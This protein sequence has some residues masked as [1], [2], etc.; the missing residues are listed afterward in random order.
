MSSTYDHIALSNRTAQVR[1]EA[2][3]NR[4]DTCWLWTGKKHVR[5]YGRFR[6]ANK[7]VLAH[8]ASWMLF[9]G[10][11]PDG[12]LVLHYC[13]TPACVNPQHLF[14]GTQLDN[15]QDCYSKRRMYRFEIA[16]GECNPAHK[17]TVGDVHAIRALHGALTLDELAM[18][19]NI[20]RAAIGLIQ[21]RKRWRHV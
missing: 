5:G 11:I 16:L 21:Q 20:S 3:I 4:T 7:W 14:L 10:P 13:D 17:I 18:H 15:M 8:R 6:L 1:F 12:Q 19:F 9:C 2:K